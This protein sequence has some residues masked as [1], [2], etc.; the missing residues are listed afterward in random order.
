VI[1]DRNET[2]A[3]LHSPGDFGVYGNAIEHAR[4]AVPAKGDRRRCRWGCKGRTT[5][6]GRVNG[7]T[8]TGGCEL[9]V[10]RW[11][12]NGPQLPASM[13]GPADSA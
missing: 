8:M 7:V 3:R 6:W 11:V 4:Y 13:Q 9:S 2:R 1:P 5:H 12:K 10:R